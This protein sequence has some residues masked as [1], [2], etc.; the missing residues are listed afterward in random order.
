MPSNEKRLAWDLRIDDKYPDHPLPEKFFGEFPGIFCCKEVGGDSESPNPHWHIAIVCKTP[1]SK[2]TITNRI[3]RLLPNHTQ[4][5][6]AVSSWKKFGSPDD[7][8][9]CYL[10][11]GTGP[12]FETQGPNIVFNHTLEDVKKLH[13]RYWLKNKQY[14]EDNK[15]RPLC[16]RVYLAVEKVE[17]FDEQSDLVFDE[18]MRQT[19]GKINDNIAWPHYQAVMYR[20]DPQHT[21]MNFRER[22]RKKVRGDRY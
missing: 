22:M 19:R 17:N 12:D 18:I 10:S 2:Q 8:L 9:L 7:E 13:E 14:V 3:K 4:C 20:I 15:E 16:D 1:E 11:K 5:E 21:S 6:R